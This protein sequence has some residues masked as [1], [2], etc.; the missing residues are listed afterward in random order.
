L[1]PYWY[2]VLS[3]DATYSGGINEVSLGLF[4]DTGQVED[5]QMLSG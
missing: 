5:V 3:L 2:I 1:I 4:A